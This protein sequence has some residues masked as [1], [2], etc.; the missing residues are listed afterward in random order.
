[1]CEKTTFTPKTF[2]AVLKKLWGFAQVGKMGY[3]FSRELESLS[4]ESV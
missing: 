2:C 1:M 3:T 4:L